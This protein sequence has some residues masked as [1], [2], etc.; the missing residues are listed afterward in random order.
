MLFAFH[1]ALSD[2]WNFESD[3]AVFEVPLIVDRFMHG[4]PSMQESVE[5]FGADVAGEVEEHVDKEV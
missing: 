4:R 3:E 5:C 2:A 1:C